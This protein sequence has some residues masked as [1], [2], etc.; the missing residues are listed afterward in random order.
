MNDTRKKVLIVD[1]EG[2]VAEVAKNAIES[3]DIE[4][5]TTFDG[6]SAID[7]IAS[8]K[9]DLILLDVMM[10]TVDG[11]ALCKRIKD[12]P[13]T[14][15][16]IVVLYTAANEPFII[17]R[18][19]AIGADDYVMKPVDSDRLRRRVRALLGLATERS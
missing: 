3:D 14:E 4:V 11:F 13:A 9:P 17:E 6:L 15:D 2:D 1:D 5:V 18:I 8:V 16:I 12:D 10:P 19:V 7:E